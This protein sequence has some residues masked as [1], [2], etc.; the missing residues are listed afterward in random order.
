MKGNECDT[1]T[2]ESENSQG[3][4]SNFRGCQAA[5]AGK[6]RVYTCL[7]VLSRPPP[8]TRSLLLQGWEDPAEFKGCGKFVSDSWRIFC[9]GHRSVRDVDDATLQRYVRW[10]THGLLE[11][12]AKKKRQ[13]QQQRQ[14]ART[15]AAGGR[16]Q[17][18]CGLHGVGRYQ[19]QG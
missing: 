7:A 18:L 11:E 9:R 6:Q 13:G 8:L 19:Q 3:R 16:G 2:E 12:K 14:G 4:L 1:V 10:L 5:W 17:F 15:G